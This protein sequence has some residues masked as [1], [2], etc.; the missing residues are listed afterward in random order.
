MKLSKVFKAKTYEEAQKLCPKGYR[1]PEI[2]ELVKLACEN[3]PIIVDTEKGD[4]IF[5]WSSTKYRDFGVRRVDRG[6]G[7]G[8]VGGW[9]DLA[10]SDD[11]GRV[12]FVRERLI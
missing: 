11:A 7:G 3:H 9:G 2:W 6:G 8:W 4:W 12:V 10:G 5:F 1:I